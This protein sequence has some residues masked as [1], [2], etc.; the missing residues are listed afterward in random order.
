MYNLSLTPAHSKLTPVCVAG[1]ETKVGLASVS[2]QSGGWLSSRLSPPVI[3]PPAG[4]K[5]CFVPPDFCPI[6][7]EATWSLKT[8]LKLKS[9]LR[10]K[11]EK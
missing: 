9:N 7:G 6:I 3:P 2:P 4:G 1:R 5:L 10:A 11:E 8:Q